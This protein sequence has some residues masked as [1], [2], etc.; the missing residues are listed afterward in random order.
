M[1]L[2]LHRIELFVDM[3]IPY[4]L[5]ML[6]GLI[7]MDYFFDDISGTFRTSVMIF[8]SIVIG[9]FLIDLS[10]K[11]HRASGVKT[12]LK[13]NW[14]EIIAVMPLA[15]IFRLIERFIIVRGVGSEIANL[16]ANHKLE[17]SFLRLVQRVGEESVLLKSSR[18]LGFFYKPHTK[19]IK[20]LQFFEKPSGHHYHHEKHK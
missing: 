16:N 20:V 11:F 5:F 1:K 4:L 19:I 7:T 8:D 17:I 6:I 12:F 2:W 3:M 14:L 9:F 18:L 15:L 10:F 13:N